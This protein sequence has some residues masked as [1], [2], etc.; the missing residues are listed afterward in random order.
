MRLGLTFLP[1]LDVLA[2]S[3]VFTPGLLDDPS[4]TVVLPLP[5]LL[6]QEELQR[7]KHLR[8]SNIKIETVKGRGV[9]GTTVPRIPLYENRSQRINS[10]FLVML[11]SPWQQMLRLIREL[12][13]TRKEMMIQETP[14]VVVQRR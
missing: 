7:R 11:S 10:Q 13:Q 5:H 9:L 4:K 8:D 1:H 2:D 3:D 6:Q 12:P 14:V